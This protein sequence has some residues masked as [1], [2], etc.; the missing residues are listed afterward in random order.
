MRKIRVEAALQLFEIRN[1]DTR[2]KKLD[3]S[4]FPAL[5]EV[6]LMDISE[7]PWSE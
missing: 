1:I 3:F 4:G 7:W 2:M 6:Q 5:A